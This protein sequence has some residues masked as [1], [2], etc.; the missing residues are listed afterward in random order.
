M[1]RKTDSLFQ[2]Y[3]RRQAEDRPRRS[4][5]VTAVEC[6]AIAAILGLIAVMFVGF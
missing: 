1:S 3:N 4:L 5:L 6:L 2:N